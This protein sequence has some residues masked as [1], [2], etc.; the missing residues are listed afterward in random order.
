MTTI[1]RVL[2]R[3]L[4]AHPEREVFCFLD[5]RGGRT[6]WTWK[7]L[8]QHASAVAVRLR[9]RIK[10]GQPV[11]IMHDAP[12]RF[13]AG[14]VGCIYAGSPAVPL[15]SRGSAQ[16][17]LLRTSGAPLVLTAEKYAD[18]IDP[19]LGT[20]VL[21]LDSIALEDTSGRA[22]A[23]DTDA[24]DPVVI[25]FTSGSTGSPKG[26]V[27][28]HRN[29]LANQDMIRRAFG[30]TADS[31]IV[32]WLPLFHDMGLMGAL[33][34]PMTLGAL[35]VL[36]RPGDFIEEPARWLRAISDFGATTSGGPDFGYVHCCNR[37]TAEQLDGV[38]LGCWQVAFDGAEPVRPA[39]LQRFARRFAEWGFR[40]QSFFPCYGLAEATVYAAGGHVRSLDGVRVDGHTVTEIGEP[41]DGL[42]LR[43]CGPEG[44]TGADIGE[45]CLEGPSVTASRW[46][47]GK[48]VP[49]PGPL[50]T[51]DLGTLRGGRLV[52]LG[53]IDD[54]IV[55]RGSNVHP[56]DL[57]DAALA[58]H[59]CLQPGGAAAFSV[60][61]DGSAGEAAEVA[62]VAEV[63]HGVEPSR[64]AEIAAAVTR[65]LGE[66]YG[67]T[68]RLYLVPPG[69]IPRTT[70][71]KVRRRACRELLNAGA[72]DGAAPAHTRAPSVSPDGLQAAVA[73]LAGC[74]AADI[75]ADR[76]LTQLGV[77]SVGA[78]ALRAD[79]WQRC[80]VELDLG[81]LLGPAS[82]RELAHHI[83]HSGCLAPTQA[84]DRPV[85]PT[86]AQ[87]AILISQALHPWSS[88][89]HVVRCFRVRG[90]VSPE[91][92]ADAVAALLR[93]HPALGQTF[94]WEDGQLRIGSTAEA[95]FLHVDHSGLSEAAA[96]RDRRAYATRS[97]DLARGPNFQLI[98]FSGLACSHWMVRA[99]HAV[100]DLWS[101]GP[102]LES[103]GAALGGQQLPD[104]IPPSV[105][106]VPGVP[107]DPTAYLDTLRDTEP[108][109][110]PL[111]TNTLRTWGLPAPIVDLPWA[112]D[113]EQTHA[114]VDLARRCQV[115]VPSL[116]L[117]LYAVVLHRYCRAAKFVVGSPTWGRRASQ[118]HTV[119]CFVNTVPVVCDASGDPTLR[120]LIHRVDQALKEAVR[121]ADVGQ[122]QWTRSWRTLAADRALFD[123]SFIYQSAPGSRGEESSL[124]LGRPSC[125]RLPGLALEAEPAAPREFLYPLDLAAGLTETGLAGY[126]GV[127]PASLPLEVGENML[128]TLLDLMAGAPER[129]DWRV[130]SG[131]V[132]TETQRAQQ[133]C[134]NRP[135]IPEL[136]AQTLLDLLAPH[137]GA[138]HRPAVIDADGILEFAD[139]DALARRL[140]QRL[141]AGQGPVALLL[142]NGRW[143]CVAFLACLYAR[144]PVVPL[145]VEAPDARLRALLAATQAPMVLTDLA[146]ADQ[147]ARIAGSRE[148][149]ALP[150]DDPPPICP[151]P[152]PHPDDVVYIVHTSGS[153]GTPKG[154]PITHR[155]LLPMLCW[156]IR[157]FDIGPGTRTLWTLPSS[158][159]FGIQE[160]VSTL[161]GGGALISMARQDRVDPQRV[162]DLM[163]QHQITHAFWTPSLARVLVPH[164]E[165]TD[166]IRVVLL[167]GEV[168]QRGLVRRLIDA[169]GPGCRIYNGY[170]PTEAAINSTMARIVSAAQGADKARSLPIGGPSGNTKLIVLNEHGS[171]CPMGAPGEL[172]I[173]GP[174]VAGGYLG[175][176]SLSAGRFLPDPAGPPGAQLYRT[177]D[178][179]RWIPGGELEF[180]GRLD[181][182]V[183]IRGHRIEPGEIEHALAEM[184]DVTAA[185]VVEATGG[186]GPELVAAVC[187]PPGVCERARIALAARLP[188]AMMPTSW[189]ELDHLPMTPNGKV[190]QSAIRAGAHHA[191]ASHQMTTASASPSGRHVA[192]A[193]AAILHLRADPGDRSFT[194][195]GGHSLA[196]IE[197]AA[198]LERRL[199][200]PIPAWA[201]IEHDT[202][203]ALA[204][205]LDGEPLEP[206]LPLSVRRAERLRA[207]AKVL[208]H[209][210]R[211]HE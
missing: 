172:Y 77:D 187:G 153:T 90:L 83:N 147:A 29:A 182:Q 44:T 108:L 104:P 80:G 28:T 210:R 190:D 100:V 194:D 79:V 8:D 138:N 197:V 109:E 193:W 9:D 71:G 34:Q 151:L 156:L 21:S 114:L 52:V 107:G 66:R 27:V 87:R 122:D 171:P 161:L 62:L 12:E 97:F 19:I 149:L 179:V 175:D 130:S 127:Q 206:E 205:F 198:V 133:H 49:H 74:P 45:I 176:R 72:L 211:P 84:T 89:H 41:A 26:V 43:I 173:G 118:D 48:R 88:A 40:E 157:E 181:R 106:G 162:V 204:R 33:M 192:A 81:T 126:L 159:D 160:V 11:A 140:A 92:L 54:V 42:T 202:I 178:R 155:N 30:H 141:A 186:S 55:F 208:R 1:T 123:A 166:T 164:L 91:V 200:R 165:R 17:D 50:R 75:D 111:G 184:P 199:G 68:V 46:V 174:G 60:D 31:R 207:T 35:A 53:R 3:N 137:A 158:F 15:A 70:S 18:A 177:G 101:L 93:R 76:S 135:R 58:A 102:I 143:W 39:T 209:I 112:L 134:W 189:L 78:A 128:A 146:H 180:L 121:Y 98:H 136:A 203:E 14:F 195:V 150:M 36:M 65:A 116:L 32:S 96:E 119:G 105:P 120:S 113:A 51:G 22:T 63:R 7:T 23:L 129:L 167:G 139:L 99:H 170:G 47:A 69:T 125:L 131:P 196:A 152:A 2:D 37:I 201:V 85:A 61:H 38:H 10:P 183:K 117:A 5:R 25:Q 191:E 185:A 154:V 86:S 168:L 4:H 59:S 64:Q 67:L 73:A 145:D 115:L 95:S 57:E 56:H 148:T 94:T 16:L 144:R 20:D 142:D 6:V 163:C 124:A 110:L 24:D 188:Q 13:V 169:L 82:L 103:L 132:L